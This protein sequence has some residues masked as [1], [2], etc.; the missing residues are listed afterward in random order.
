MTGYVV[1]S[2]DV[3][4]R[5]LW[6]FRRT[7]ADMWAEYHY[8]TMT[9]LLEQ[10]GMGTYAEA[11]GVSLEIPEDTLLNKKHV[12]IPM[13]EFW[14]RDLHPRLMYLQDV[15]GAA[16]ASHVYGKPLT[17]A[18][19][20]TGG[21]YESPF[22]LKKVGDYW[23]AHGINRM[24]F[25]TSA[26]QPLDTKPGNT[27][28]GTH[29]NR[30]ITWAEQAGPVMTYFARQLFMLQQ[31]RFVADI[32]YLLNE[33]APSTPPIWGAGTVPVPPSGY[34]FDFI[35]ADAL[36]TL[37]SVDKAGYIVL[38]SGMRYRLLMLPES[39]RMRP[40]LLR[41]ILALVEAGA[42]VSGPRP[43]ASPSLSGYPQTDIEVRDLAAAI[44]GDLDGISRTIRNV[45][46]GR[47]FWGR[48][49]D[50]I[51]RLMNV[52]KDVE[53]GG[54]RIGAELAWLH[55][56]AGETDIYY[57]A[58][59]TDER[60]DLEMRFRVANREAE[61]WRPDTGAIEP[62][63][64]VAQGDRTRVPL[65]LDPRE[66]VFVVFPRPASTPSR[67][68]PAPV[69]TTAATIDGRWRVDFP[70]NLGAPSQ[71]MLPVLQS[72]TT[73]ANDGV[74]YFSGTATYTKSVDAPRTWFRTGARTMLDLGIVGDMAEVSING[75]SIGVL[76][77]PPYRVDVT[78]ALRAGRNEIAIKVTNQWTNRIL[79]D[80]TAP[81]DRQ[82]LSPPA[83][84]GGRGGGAAE[85]AESGLLGPVTVVLQ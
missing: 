64:F 12:T 5:F 47:V 85:P 51:L 22:T 55:R 29:I 52:P 44:W 50:E 16:S 34:D 67:A 19:S 82:V 39:R 25:H 31:G 24:V 28:V 7:L 14:V 84:G 43:N 20:F 40:E 71:I 61:L 68:V 65:K 8:G 72:W 1:G 80:R 21:G 49:P 27:M 23:L 42:T 36:L 46:N 33:G 32:A 13:G 53:Y 74:R 78:D 58:N 62:A 45:G 6:D 4:D 18:E 76:W 10:R 37:A 54:G 30:N 3:S 2:A 69:T 59:L 38:P 57:V 26:H 35:N 48:A 79:G 9:R 56:R 75:R 17:A 83:A 81:A 66:M 11:A 73:H 63:S 77:K 70:A 41:R 60:Q 15:R